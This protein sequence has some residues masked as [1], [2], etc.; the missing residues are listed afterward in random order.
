MVEIN[1]SESYLNFCGSNNRH[2]R[3]MNNFLHVKSLYDL[4]W[5]SAQC[6]T[7]S[8]R[9]RSGLYELRIRI[10][11]LR[12]QDRIVRLWVQKYWLRCRSLSFQYNRVLSL[13]L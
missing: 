10:A 12:N 13:S 7:L 3:P 5:R 2:L 8:E 11:A 9:I 1:K 4:T 6:G